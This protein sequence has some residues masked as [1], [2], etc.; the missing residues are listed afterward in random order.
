MVPNFAEKRVFSTHFK[1]YVREQNLYAKLKK[2]GLISWVC[3]QNVKNRGYKFSMSVYSKFEK[4]ALV[5]IFSER[6][7]ENVKKKG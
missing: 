4:R 2:K 1:R 7:L 5:K 3:T 6:V